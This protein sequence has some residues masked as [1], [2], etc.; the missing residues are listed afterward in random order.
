MQFRVF[1]GDYRPTFDEVVMESVNVVSVPGGDP[2]HMR[3]E[4]LYGRTS[5]FPTEEVR[6]GCVV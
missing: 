5:K 1:S 6:K 4:A 2:V 3:I